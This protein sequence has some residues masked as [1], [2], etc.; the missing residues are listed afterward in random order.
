MEKGY[1]GKSNQIILAGYCWQL[2]RESPDRHKMKSS[3]K[4]DF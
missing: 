4:K 3:R 1:Q 2:E